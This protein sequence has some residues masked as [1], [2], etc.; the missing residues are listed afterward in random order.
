MQDRAT[1]RALFKPWGGRRGL[2]P[3]RPEPQSGAL[4]IEL[5]PPFPCDYSNWGESC[6][7]GRLV[8]WGGEKCLVAAHADVLESH[9]AQ[10]R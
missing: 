3:Q 7:K 5:L 6:Q 10:T 8:L 1:T 2:N 4:P 9:G